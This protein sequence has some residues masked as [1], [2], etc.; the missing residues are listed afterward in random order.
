MLILGIFYG[1]PLEGPLSLGT[2]LP[3][4]CGP[5]PL[6]VGMIRGG[7]PARNVGLFRSPAGIPLESR[8]VSGQYRLPLVLASSRVGGGCG[9][10]WGIT[11]GPGGGLPRSSAIEVLPS[12]LK[13]CLSALMRTSCS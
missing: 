2:G 12:S 8:L 6:L 10:K 7:I 11:H 1:G 5:S 9:M 4:P 3:G 13:T